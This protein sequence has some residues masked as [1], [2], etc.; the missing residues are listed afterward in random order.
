MPHDARPLSLPDG[1][2]AAWAHGYALL[3]GLLRCPPDAARLR[4]LAALETRV[5]PGDDF[6]TALQLLGLAA[7]QRSA[8]QVDDEFH[9]L[10][11]GLGRGELVPYG[12][13]YLTGHLMERPLAALRRDLAAL[14]F[15]RQP[16][17]R[18]P[19]DHAAALLEVMAQLI[20]GGD[21]LATQ[22]RFHRQHIAPW[23][24]RFFDDLTTA[25]SAV[26]YRAVGRLGIAFLALEQGVLG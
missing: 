10:F 19:E 21:D 9:D 13:W 26:F 20:E 15:Q 23:M 5:H 4:A 7:R 16:Y 6:G 18:D 25:D 11:I 3:A 2:Q 1:E 14:G 8:E 22:A 24:S 12:S 17:N